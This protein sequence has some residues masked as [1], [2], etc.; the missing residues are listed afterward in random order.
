MHLTAFREIAHVAAS[1][2]EPSFNQEVLL[3]AVVS[4][5]YWQVTWDAQ[6]REVKSAHGVR[7]SMINYM[8]IYIPPV[9]GM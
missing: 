1:S 8:V 7:T 9:K 5:A 2:L 6:T 3:E 4:I